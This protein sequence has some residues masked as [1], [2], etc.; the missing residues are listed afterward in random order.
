MYALGKGEKEY[1]PIGLAINLTQKN[2]LSK[3]N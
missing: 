1:S 3:I 2:Y